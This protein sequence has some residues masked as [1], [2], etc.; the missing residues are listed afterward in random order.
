MPEQ[1]RVRPGV[2][3]ATRFAMSS[4]A[5]YQGYIDYIDRDEASRTQNADRYDLFVSDYMDNPR[6]TNRVQSSD[7]DYPLPDSN[8]EKESALF[9]AGHDL[10]TPAEKQNLKHQFQKAQQNGS[11]LWQTVIS[12]DNDYLKECG[13]LSPDG[14]ALDES[15]L[16]T[17]TR[18]AMLDFFRREKMEIS[19]VWAASI[20]YNTDNIHIHVATVEPH[21]TRAKVQYNGR[22]QYRGK[23]KPSTIDGMKSRVVNTI[24]D[25][26]LHLAEINRVI[27]ENIVAVKRGRPL[28]RNQLFQKE[29]RQILQQLPA[30][31]RRW[32][33]GDH[34]LDGIRDQIDR[35]TERYIARYNR[36][37]FAELN[38]KLD[39]QQS[40]LMRAYGTGQSNRYMDYKNTK[41][42]DL[43]QRLGNAVLSEMRETA[44][45]MDGIK[46][47][48]P[49]KAV[50]KARAQKVLYDSCRDLKRAFRKTINH[51]KN[52]R[53]FDYL[54][55]LAAE[56]DDSR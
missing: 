36:E 16:R 12:F 5:R 55:E 48:T 13:A 49:N 1:E 28:S 6:K 32:H 33:Y 2:I 4:D 40:R 8:D 11:P 38:Q 54:Q 18:N 46:K 37:D 51:V 19:G 41:L 47:R 34:A 25:S 56:P 39:A 22:E 20:H 53:D 35:F 7:P 23:I 45:Q 42:A 29:Y 44:A 43:R 9:T 50:V 26:T 52:Q 27:R 15:V 14:R 10:L 24:S 31:H 21:P 30:D 3:V 17:A